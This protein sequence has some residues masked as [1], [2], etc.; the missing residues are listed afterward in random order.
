[1]SSQENFKSKNDVLPTNSN[2]QLKQGEKFVQGCSGVIYAHIIS[3][4]YP[5][6][7][8]GKLGEP[9]VFVMP[10]NPANAIEQLEEL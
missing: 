3:H 9:V 1:M 2:L 4:N 5:N 7:I 10:N 6:Q 8:A